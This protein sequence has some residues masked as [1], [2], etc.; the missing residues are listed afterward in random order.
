MTPEQAFQMN[1]RKLSLDVIRVSELL[2]A[3]ID[4]ILVKEIKSLFM[5]EPQEFSMR[6]F[7][8]QKLNH[9]DNR[10]FD[11]NIQAV[12]DDIVRQYN[13]EGWTSKIIPET[14]LVI[15]IKVAKS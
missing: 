12:V 14:N 10:L 11:E 9:K 4:E 6:A 5:D 15:S 13:S 2:I 7:A 1:K 3:F 8:D